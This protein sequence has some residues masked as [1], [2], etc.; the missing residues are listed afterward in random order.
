M[1]QISIKEASTAECNDGIVHRS[2]SVT[3]GRVSSVMQGRS[4]VGT[5]GEVCTLR[6]NATTVVRGLGR[7][8][9]HRLL[10]TSLVAWQSHLPSLN[11][12]PS[13]GTP[14]L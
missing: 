6:R 9:L 1:P 7:A 8:R 11:K 14:E 12:G 3:R 2:R 13:R 5:P 4:A 10:G